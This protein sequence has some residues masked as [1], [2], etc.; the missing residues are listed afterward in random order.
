MH[1]ALDSPDLIRVADYEEGP[2][3]HWGQCCRTMHLYTYK[4]F[5]QQLKRMPL[6]FVL[7]VFNDKIVKQRTQQTGAVQHSYADYAA[8]T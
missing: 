3:R 2:A 6:D 5:S 4:R 8:T 7:V 1:V